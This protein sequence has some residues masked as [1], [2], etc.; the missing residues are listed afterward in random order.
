M[1]VQ[2]SRPSR[3]VA[4]AKPRNGNLHGGWKSCYTY[5]KISSYILFCR[6]ANTFRKREYAIPRNMFW[7]PSMT[8][9]RYQEFYIC[10][11]QLSSR[12]C[13]SYCDRVDLK[14]GFGTMR[15]QVVKSVFVDRIG[16]SGSFCSLPTVGLFVSTIVARL[17]RSL[18][19]AGSP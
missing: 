16:G 17:V 9:L 15:C 2:A 1:E 4:P 7:L 10:E 5:D 12:L 18:D 3:N 19:L 14:G 8:T 6:F 13:F 11:H